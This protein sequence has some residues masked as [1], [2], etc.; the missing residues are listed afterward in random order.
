MREQDNRC[1]N[2]LLV[3][4]IAIGA[5]SGPKSIPAFADN[6]RRSAHNAFKRPK[7]SGRVPKINQATECA[8]GLRGGMARHGGAVLPPPITIGN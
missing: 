5:N 8:I 6:Y 4:L 3:T 1:N 2:Y 7:M